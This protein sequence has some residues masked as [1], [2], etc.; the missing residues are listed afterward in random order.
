VSLPPPGLSGLDA[1]WSREVTAADSTGVV[2][3]WHVLDSHAGLPAGSPEPVGTLLCVHGN[4]S[5]SYL[6]RR[7]VAR[8]PEGWR[9]IAVD[10]LDMGYSERTGTL[11]PLAQR[12]DDLDSLTDALGLTGPGSDGPIITVAHD[13]GGPIS[14]GWVLRHVDRMAGVVLSNTAVHQPASASAP[15][16]IRATRLPGML[17]AITSRTRTFIRAGLFLSRPVPP[18]E[19]RA[20]YYAPYSEAG[21]RGAIEDFVADIPLDP[22][23]V[24][25]APLDA[26]ADGLD[27]LAGIPVLLLWGPRD[28]VFSDLY[29]RDL[30]GR[31]PH[32]DVHRYEGSSHFVPEDAPTFAADVASWVRSR[33][34]PAEP[35]A[36][37]D[38]PPVPDSG[39]PLWAGISERAADPATSG[40]PAVTELGPGGVAATLS[41]AELDDRVEN[42]AAGLTAIGVRRGERIALLVPPGTDL[43]AVLYGIWR[44]GIVAVVVDAGLGIRGMRVALRSAGPAY[45]IGTARGLAAAR[46]MGTGA[47]LISVGPVP[48]SARRGLG[49]RRRLEEI[50]ARGAEAQ[51]PDPP[52]AG[53]PAVVAFTSG[54]TGPAKGVL[55]QHGQLQAQREQLASL[56][57]I[58]ASDRLVA[59]F[60]PFALFG[61]ALGI[62]SAVPDMN[63][64]APRTLTARAMGDAAAAIDAT[65]VFASP[66]ALANVVVT[67]DAVDP[68]GRAA[69]SR[70][71]LLLST[72]APV[73][74]ET[75]HAMRRLMPSA[76]AHAPYGMT[77]VLPV[78][79]IDLAGLDEAGL[80]NGVCVGRPVPGVE[81]ELAPLDAEGIPD[82]ERTTTA[83]VT[84]EVCVR[85]AHTKARYDRLWVTDRVATPSPGWHRT[86]DVGHFDA[87]G[88]LWIEGRLVHVIVT[89]EGPVTPV[90]IERRV[91][92]VA[93]VRR[94]AVVGVGP[95]GAAQVVVVVE[96]A[97]VRRSGLAPAS[98][99]DA[100]R[101]AAGDTAGAV[102]GIAAVLVV[103]T[104]PVDI[105]HNS[106]IDRV[107]VGR[108][109]QRVLD[110]GR[111]GT[112]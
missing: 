104:L 10:H 59:A 22:G 78:A 25:A 79:D 76:E 3:T 35:P 38:A 83:D 28:P 51:R 82:D 37:S 44:A 58:T 86:G 39:R 105:R 84:G 40:N 80:G 41:F 8:P 11:R 47:Q 68:R 97:D 109:A 53:D 31:L 42:V 33:S 49:V 19:V 24:S 61:A 2:R 54:A 89:A 91:E 13:W 90:G 23:D 70:V 27:A 9:V 16:V 93:G 92:A 81:V 110:G 65:M 12:V 101:A 107:A 67:A 64:T 43:T 69:L 21:R 4:P 88:R 85:A 99:R 75:L 103:R 72:G 32:A 100:V 102:P 56:Y 98:L 57:S 96:R 87:S 34:L 18:P 94:A 29:L 30:I 50:E 6:W 36:A 46:L 77:E 7:V 17:P 60:G 74:A 62:P 108:W 63:L 66:A 15:T 73:P 111:L 71:R 1:R 48:A 14:L 52:G 45:V 95:R 20:G 106:K 112:P 55:Y 26:I 5:W